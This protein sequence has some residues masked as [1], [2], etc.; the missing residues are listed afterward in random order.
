[1]QQTEYEYLPIAIF[2]LMPGTFLSLNIQRSI[3]CRPGRPTCKHTVEPHAQQPGL[4]RETSQ[5]D[6]LAY[7]AHQNPES[8]VV[9]AAQLK[10]E[11]WYIQQKQK[12]LATPCSIKPPP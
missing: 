12:R 7:I 10:T 9:L 2:R 4:S 1:M 3:S 6:L 8:Q 11:E 5:D